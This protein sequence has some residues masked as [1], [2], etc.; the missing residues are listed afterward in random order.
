MLMLVHFAHEFTG[1]RVY[2]DRHVGFPAR[3]MNK[4]SSLRL[5]PSRETTLTSGDPSLVNSE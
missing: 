2:A 1:A 3:Q 5:S 4:L